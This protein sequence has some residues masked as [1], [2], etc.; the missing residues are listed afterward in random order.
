MKIVI[1]DPSMRNHQG[2][3]SINLGDVI[4]REAI[5]RFMES[6][7]RGATVHRLSTHQYLEECHYDLIEQSDF[8]FIGGTNLL[9]SDV[10]TYNQWKLSDHFQRSPRIKNVILFG[11]GWWQYQDRPTNN[12][13]EFYNAILSKSWIHSARDSYTVMKLADMGIQNAVNTSCPTVWGLNGIEPNRKD[14]T[15]Q[16]CIFTLTDYYRNPLSDTRLIEI[17]LSSYREKIFFFP[18]GSEDLNYIN[19]LE[20]FDTNRSR[21]QVL[22]H[23]IEALD[24]CIHAGKINYIGTRLHTGTRCL[25]TG[26]DSLIVAVDNRATEIGKD[27][28]LPVV[29]REE[30]FRVEEWIAGERIFRPISLPMLDIELWKGQFNR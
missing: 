10:E 20:I 22:A 21:I 25:Q 18:Q 7:F 16:N 4:I 23:S 17:I 1:L 27:I 13:T 28:N 6:V 15:C 11:V 5:D 8:V 26:I 29:N 12:T 3:P 9:S 14:T 2:K 19:T 24:D 30:L